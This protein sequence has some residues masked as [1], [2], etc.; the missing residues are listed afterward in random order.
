MSDWRGGSGVGGWPPSGGEATIGSGTVADP[1][2][3]PIHQLVRRPARRRSWPRQ[4]VHNGSLDGWP[5]LNGTCQWKL[6][7][8]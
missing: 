7:S 2:G 8:S 4:V 5:Q 1:L 6:D 3:Q